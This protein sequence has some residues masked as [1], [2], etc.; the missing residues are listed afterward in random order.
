MVRIWTILPKEHPRYRKYRTVDLSTRSKAH[1]LTGLSFSPTI[2]AASP[3]PRGRLSPNLWLAATFLIF[4][5]RNWNWRFA[6]QWVSSNLH[7]LWFS[8]IERWRFLVLLARHRPYFRKQFIF[9]DWNVTVIWKY[10]VY[11]QY[12]QSMMVP[13]KVEISNMRKCY[14]RFYIGKNVIRL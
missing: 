4:V 11:S 13:V 14:V 6:I 10:I 1:E 9:V 8:F 2:S 12:M 3:H 5:P 7:R